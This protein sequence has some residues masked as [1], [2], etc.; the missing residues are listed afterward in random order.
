MDGLEF[1]KEYQKNIGNYLPMVD[2][3]E[4][5]FEKRDPGN[6]VVNIGWNCGLMEGG[7]PY[8]SE[9]WAMDYLSMLSV[10]ISSIGIENLS[11]A[12]VD[13]LCEK[14]RVY[15]RINVSWVPTVKPF[16]DTKGNAFYSVNLIVGD[17]E[18]VYVDGT[19]THYPF[20]LLNEHNRSRHAGTG[21]CEK[22][23]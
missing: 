18:R 13:A 11:P 10:F 15:H 4:W 1:L 17:E 12:E 23:G 3:A 20:S 21:G 16:T 8:F 19:S 7:R 5:I 22:K 14:N 6:M 9:F 2:H